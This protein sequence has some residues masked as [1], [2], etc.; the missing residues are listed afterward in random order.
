MKKIWLLCIFLISGAVHAQ[1]LQ[2]HYDFRQSDNPV[3]DRGYPTAT[4]EMFQPDDFGATFWFV[5]MDFDTPDNGM[6]LAYWE[7]ARYFSLGEETGLSLTLQFNDGV[8]TTG[9]LPRAWLAG[10]S[11]LFNIGDWSLPV[12]LL[13]RHAQG[14]QGADFQLTMVWDKTIWDDRIQ[15]V[16][17]IDLWT[18]DPL[19][20]KNREKEVAVQAEPQIWYRLPA[21]LSI[22]GEI[23]ISRYF[24]PVEHWQAYPTLGVKWQF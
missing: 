20:R 11:Y 21:G 9:S 7:L 6:N 1:N 10:I 24:L 23:E 16:G 5:D 2:L 12:D 8:T 4:L 15:L 3:L 22:G 17:Y 19:V 14:S 18:Q 13:Y